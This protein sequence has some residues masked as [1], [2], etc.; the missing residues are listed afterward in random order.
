MSSLIKNG[1]VTSLTPVTLE[2]NPKLKPENSNHSDSRHSPRQIA[3]ATAD[4]IE[5]QRR[6]AME[7]GYAE[8]L[9]KAQEELNQQKAELQK[10]YDLL[11]EDMNEGVKIQEEILLEITQKL[12]MYHKELAREFESSLLQLTIECL[13]KLSGE[14]DIFKKIIEESIT[15]YLEQNKLED[16]IYIRL[17]E[18]MEPEL[19]FLKN[20]LEGQCIIMFEPSLDAGQCLVTSGYST[21]DIGPSTQLEQ[22]REKFIFT[23]NKSQNNA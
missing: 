12:Q 6:K 9:R 23:F 18:I 22:I 16:K 21:H 5:L 3:Q 17:P 7:A 10:Q 4:D 14:R 8:G 19:R 1:Q 13:Y 2:A 20:Q 11:K 15:R